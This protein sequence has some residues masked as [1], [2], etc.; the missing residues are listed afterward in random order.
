[1]EYRKL[2]Q[3]SQVK[4][5]EVVHRNGQEL[6][7][8]FKLPQIIKSCGIVKSKSYGTIE[9]FF[10]MLVMILERCRSINS[11]L[12]SHY[13]QKLKTPFNNMLNNEYYNWRN[14]LYRVAVVFKSSCPVREVMCRFLLLM[15]QLKR[16]PVTRVK[17][18]L[19]L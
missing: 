9:M 16:K 12:N 17:I 11:G 3:F 14:L 4:T 15:I 2:A 18:H 6:F 13:K 7:K 8:K 1:M 19:G 5:S 10:L